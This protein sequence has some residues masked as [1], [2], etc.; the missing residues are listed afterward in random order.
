MDSVA[1]EVSAVVTDEALE[2]AMDVVDSV[3]DLDGD[4]ME[5]LDVD[6][7]SY[8]QLFDPIKV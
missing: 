4:P 2:A 1:V 3:E 8:S 6:M 7:V 5:V